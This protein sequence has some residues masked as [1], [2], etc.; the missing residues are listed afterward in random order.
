MLVSKSDTIIKI[1]IKLIILTYIHTFILKNFSKTY[2]I[3]RES[4]V[5]YIIIT[6]AGVE[7]NSAQT[8]LTK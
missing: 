5:E 3:F 1:I 4:V 7:S 6:C 2:G 8:S